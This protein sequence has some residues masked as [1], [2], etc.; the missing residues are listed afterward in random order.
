MADGFIMC[1]V[2]TRNGRSTFY[3]YGLITES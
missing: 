1:W 3:E 2:L